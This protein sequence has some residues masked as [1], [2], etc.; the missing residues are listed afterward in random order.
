MTIHE[1]V[2]D[3][4]VSLVRQLAVVGG[5]IAVMAVAGAS[6]TQAFADPGDTGSVETTS[7]IKASGGVLEQAGSE[8]APGEKHRTK[9]A[10]KQQKNGPAVSGLEA[11][12]AALAE[13]V[14]GGSTSD[15]IGMNKYSGDGGPYAR[16]ALTF[17][18]GEAA[19][20]VELTYGLAVPGDK[21]YFAQC[22]GSQ[23][24][25]EVTTLADGSV[26]QTYD[27]PFGGGK[28]GETGTNLGAARLVDGYTVGL[29]VQ[30]PVDE[31]GKVLDPETVL[32]MD[33]LQQVLSQP[34]WAD[35]EPLR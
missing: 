10:N 1:T 31:R 32:T 29:W 30:V 7:V 15:L 12:Q 27:I 2:A 25:C 17:G 20:D 14:P 23:S 9:H 6:A 4:G 33:Q 19:S 22:D 5:S 34:V 21:E 28:P 18:I 35:L 26:M 24:N 8:K 13:A 11:L 16:G 3:E